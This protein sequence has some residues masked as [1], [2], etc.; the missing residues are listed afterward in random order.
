MKQRVKDIFEYDV[1]NLNREEVS[2]M[3]SFIKKGLIN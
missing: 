3:M 2:Q 1:I